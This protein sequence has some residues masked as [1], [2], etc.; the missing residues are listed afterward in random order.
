M[1]RRISTAALLVLASVGW[2]ESA[3]ATPEYPPTIDAVLSTPAMTVRCPNPQFRCLI[4]HTTSRGGEGTAEQVFAD[5]LGDLG[6]NRGNDA[7]LLRS[8]LAQLSETEDSDGDGTPD[9][10]EL[11]ACGNPSGDSLGAGPEYG[12]DGAQLV[13]VTGQPP[14]LVLLAA[15]VA[16]L[17]V[18]LGRRKRR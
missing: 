1:M 15:G 8:A 11:R 17:L 3:R 7:N 14:G 10:E 13:P 5:T 4:C 16:T 12:C 9:K 6:L 18:R 2:G